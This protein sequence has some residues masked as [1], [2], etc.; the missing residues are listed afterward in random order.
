MTRS[1]HHLKL[2]LGTLIL[3]VC[4]VLGLALASRDTAISSE[5]A[6][7]LAA[8]TWC[9]TLFVVAKRTPHG[10]FS[11]PF[12][13]L[14][15]LGTFHLGLVIPAQF[16]YAPP[17]ETRWLFDASMPKALMLCSVA[18]AAF[19]VGVGL[20]AIRDSHTVSSSCGSAELVDDR[21]DRVLFVAGACLGTVGIATM[22]FGALEIELTDLTYNELF[23]IRQAEDAR[24]FG[25]GFLFAVMGMVIAA[26][27]ANVRQIP[28]L[29]VLSACFLAPLFVYGFRGHVIVYLI[30]FLLIWHRKEPRR[31]RV[32]GLVG[33]LIVAVLAPAVRLARSDHTADLTD[34]LSEIGALDVVLEAG[35]S[36][37]PLVETVDA[38]EHDNVDYWYGASYLAAIVRVVPNTTFRWTAPES[39]DISTPAAWITSR[40][41]PFTFRTGGGIGYSGVAEPYLNFGA[42]GV[43]V[44]FLIVG[45]VLARWDGRTMGLHRTAVVAT[46]FAALLWTVRN[47]FSNLTRPALWGAAF[48]LVLY[49]LRMRLRV[50]T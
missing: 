50:G 18:F 37:R 8:M 33:V 22:V 28:L 43:L 20:A 10:L 15:L 24:L 23:A 5:A 6:A 17:L 39:R 2:T 14:A 19:G 36:M 7:T 16:G 25:V 1:N 48:V 31:A 27:G 12:A 21:S 46:T 38:L 49:S 9:F 11:F 34:S 30:S 35:G 4:A 42:I 40:V 13:Y 45:Y 41:A 32:M 44:F 29:A 47:D 3:S 26:V